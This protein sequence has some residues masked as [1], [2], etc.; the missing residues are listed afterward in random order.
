MTGS[1]LIT[2]RSFG[3][4][5]EDTCHTLENAGFTII[6]AESQHDPHELSAALPH[7]E[8]WIAGTGPIT[9]DH[10][11]HAPRLKVI[12]RYG[13]GYDAVDLAA[14]TAHGIIVT[15]TPG[16]NSESVADLALT[17][18]LTALRMVK[19][20]DN[21]V[22][23]ADWAVIRGREISSLR[24]GV[25]GFGRIGRSFAARVS[26]LGASVL[27][28]D[29]LI[30]EVE[31]LPKRHARAASF[32]ELSACDAVSLHAPGGQRLVDATWL[33]SVRGMTLVNTAR[34]DLVDESATADAIRSGHLTSY[35][36]DTLDTESHGSSES[37]L[38]AD[39]LADRVIIT[40]HLGAQT[41]QAIDRMGVAAVNN[42]LLVLNGRSA[43]N[44]VTV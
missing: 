1:I 31:T 26:G 22:R 11:A 36:A 14:A 2:S 39:D 44:P 21:A 38:L 42:V 15:N 16:A 40:P 19:A 12:A 5:N 34:A 13:V 23:R 4:G 20:G 18:L 9:E 8:A 27:A 29:P 25:A 35:A 33:H 7:V 30:S 43:L 17:L 10:L 28:Y 41:V 3:T 37:P 6:R 24:I 32:I